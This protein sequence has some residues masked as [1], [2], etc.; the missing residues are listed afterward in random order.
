M[1]RPSAELNQ[2][3]SLSSKN[4]DKIVDQGY[5]DLMVWQRMMTNEDG[6]F[7]EDSDVLLKSFDGSSSSSSSPTF[8]GNAPLPRAAEKTTA[9]KKKLA[10]SASSSKKAP[11]KKGGSS[12][13][14]SKSVLKG[15]YRALKFTVNGDPVRFEAEEIHEE[16]DDAAGK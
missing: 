7:S 13:E 8:G 12:P 9:S 6:N 16:S 15:G 5:E 14:P 3:M 4:K 2:T 10:S 1:P 11:P